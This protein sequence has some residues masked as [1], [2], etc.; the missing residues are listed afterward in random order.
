MRA[1][2]TEVLKKYLSEKIKDERKRRKKTQTEMAD[3][4]EMDVRSY[5]ELEYGKSLCGSVTL[6]LFL[7]RS[8][9]DVEVLLQEAREILDAEDRKKK[10]N[11]Q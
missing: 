11:K 2:Y 8:G 5:V 7:T 4:L 3:E 10:S 1:K 9:V 6:V